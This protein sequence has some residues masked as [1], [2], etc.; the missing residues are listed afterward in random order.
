MHKKYT[1]DGLAAIS[2]S[3]DQ[4]SED[5]QTKENV[6]AFLRKRGAAFTNLLLDERGDLW[7]KKL[8]FSAPPCYYVFSRQGKWTMFQPDNDEFDF[9][10]TVEKLVVELLREK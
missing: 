7:E 1:K 2:V 3:L 6:L 9:Q 10:A 8:R 4:L 5:P